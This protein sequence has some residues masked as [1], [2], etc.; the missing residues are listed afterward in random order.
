ME[1]AREFRR[2]IQGERRHTLRS[3][4]I[5]H[6]ANARRTR[7]PKFQPTPICEATD[8][9]PARWFLPWQLWL[10]LGSVLFA[11]LSSLPRRNYSFGVK[12]PCIERAKRKEITLLVFYTSTLQKLEEECFFLH[13]N[14][15]SV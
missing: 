2:R 9:S 5:R 12:E 15:F 11:S 8:P 4:E 14:Y 7:P 13:L 1:T 3:T 10:P 6:D